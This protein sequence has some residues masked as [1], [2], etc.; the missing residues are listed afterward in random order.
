MWLS[1]EREGGVTSVGSVG[2]GTG[3]G[4]V[5]GRYGTTQGGSAGG[6][7]YAGG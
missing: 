5:R 1:L 6:Y 4:V 2:R 3:L 7:Y